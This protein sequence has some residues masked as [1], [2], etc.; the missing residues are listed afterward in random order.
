MSE[1]LISVHFDAD[2]TPLPPRTDETRAAF[3][4]ALRERPGVSAIWG[5]Q[6]TSGSAR[7]EAYVIRKGRMRPFQPAGAFDA[8]A[9]TLF[10][11]HRI[12][13]RYVGHQTPA[14]P[15]VQAVAP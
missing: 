1:Q 3:A 13:V 11:E 5:R 9:R 14:G 6:A 7:Q 4:A 2:P 8:A 12:Y 15:A 10:G